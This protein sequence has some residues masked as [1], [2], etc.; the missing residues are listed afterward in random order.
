MK[1][2]EEESERRNDKVRK[3][4][5]EDKKNKE[6]NRGRGNRGKTERKDIH[7]YSHFYFLRISLCMCVFFS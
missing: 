5:V 3:E 4:K 7:A 1:R 6:R 2:R